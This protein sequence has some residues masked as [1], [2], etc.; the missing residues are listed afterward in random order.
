MSSILAGNAEKGCKF[1]ESW[2]YSLFSFL[3]FCKYL[4]IDFKEQKEDFSFY[5]KFYLIS[6]FLFEGWP[7]RW[8]ADKKSTSSP[9]RVLNSYCSVMGFYNF[10]CDRQTQPEVPFGTSGF[11][12]SVETIKN[13]SFFLI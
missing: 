10:I 11:F 8:K 12:C 6:F 9:Q 5:M 4:E 1:K 13:F 3:F 2:T 7:V